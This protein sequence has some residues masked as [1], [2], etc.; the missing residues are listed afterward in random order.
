MLLCGAG[1]SGAMSSYAFNALD[2][3]CLEAIGI[4]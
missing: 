3:S 4:L 2:I 1:D